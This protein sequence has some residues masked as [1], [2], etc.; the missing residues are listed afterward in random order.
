MRMLMIVIYFIMAVVVVA[1]AA[2]N[3]DSSQ[4]NLY[5]TTLTMPNALWMLLS[6]LFGVFIGFFLLMGRFLRLKSVVYKVKN[7]LKLTEKEIKNLRAIPLQ[8]QH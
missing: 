5:F 6:C 2:L 8:D 4:I 3:A 7:Q 1:F